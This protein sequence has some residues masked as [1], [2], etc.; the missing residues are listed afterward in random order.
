MNAAGSGRLAGR[1][2]IVTR[3]AEQADVLAELIVRQGGQPIVVP[4][5]EIVPT[6]ATVPSTTGFD[7]VVVTSPNGAAHLT[8]IADGVRLAAVG[9]ATASALRRAVPGCSV[10]LVPSVQRAAGLVAEFG[11]GPGRVL[12]VQAVDAATTLVDGLVA[13]GWT[14]EAVS[15]YRSVS[16]APSEEQRQAAAGADV[17]LLTSGSAGRGWAAAF[18]TQTCP[19]VVAIGPQCA[20]AASAAGLTVTH[21]ATSHS[22]ESLVAAIPFMS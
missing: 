13:G 4:L 12:V 21:V 6:G 17:L 2:V 15:P 7:W 22:L 14:V 9:Q 11:R 3:A 19:V 16:R 5:I 8:E 10:D 18:G 20:A 1:R